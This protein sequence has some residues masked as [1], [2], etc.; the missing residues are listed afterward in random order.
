MILV[1]VVVYMFWVIFHLF[2]N[3]KPSVFVPGHISDQR[4]RLENNEAALRRKDRVISELE[5]KLDREK[6]SNNSQSQIEDISIPALKSYLYQIQKNK[7][8]HQFF[9][10]FFLTSL[11]FRKLYQQR[12]QRY[13]I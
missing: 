10:I 7:F 11:T 12:M 4:N 6:L 5:A 13:I 2:I 8:F 9:L 1:I 3:S